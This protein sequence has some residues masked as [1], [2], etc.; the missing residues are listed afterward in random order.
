M[1]SDALGQSCGSIP[2]SDGLM[3]RE[4]VSEPVAEPEVAEETAA[5]PD[6]DAATEPEQDARRGGVVAPQTHP[7]PAPAVGGVRGRGGL[8]GADL[9]GY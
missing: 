5:D 9:R 3:T 1:V 7:A 4:K 6:T 8:R 2:R